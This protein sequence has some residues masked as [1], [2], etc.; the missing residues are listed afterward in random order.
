VNLKPTEFS[1]VATML[2]ISQIEKPRCSATIDQIQV[3][4]GD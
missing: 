4:L 1:F 3:A 2:Q